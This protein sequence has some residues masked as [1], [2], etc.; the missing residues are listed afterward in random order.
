[1]DNAD[2]PIAVLISGL[3][4]LGSITFLIIWALQTAYA[5]N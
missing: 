4:I 2:S 3:L 1:M 5:Y